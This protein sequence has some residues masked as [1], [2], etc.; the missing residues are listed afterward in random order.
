MVNISPVEAL[1]Y[2][3]PWEA[4]VLA[5]FKSFF[6]NILCCE[7]LSDAAVVRV[8]QLCIIIL[9]IKQVVNIDIVNVALYFGQVDIICIPV[10]VFLFVGLLI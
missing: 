9:V 8:A 3:L 6:I 2:E 7:I 5:Y 10:G 1:Y 4:K